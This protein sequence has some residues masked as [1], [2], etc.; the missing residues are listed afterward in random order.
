MELDK[1]IVVKIR[2]ISWKI[3]VAGEECTNHVRLI[4]NEAGFDC[5]EPVPDPS[6]QEP[7]VFSFIATPNESTPMTAPELS[8]I[9]NQ[10]SSIEMA[11]ET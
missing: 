9:F 10:D 7:P 11:F 4:L 5:T 3:C 2:P 6:I 8:A 1:A